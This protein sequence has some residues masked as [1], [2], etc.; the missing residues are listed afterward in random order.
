MTLNH[1]A[2]PIALLMVALAI[3]LLGIIVQLIFGPKGDRAFNFFAATAVAV[4][5]VAVLSFAYLII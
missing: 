2:I 1:D 3:L 4:I 5:I